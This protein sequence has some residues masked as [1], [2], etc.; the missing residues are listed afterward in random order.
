LDRFRLSGVQPDPPHDSKSPRPL[1]L[2]FHT[3]PFAFDKASSFALHGLQYHKTA[4]FLLHI[5]HMTLLVSNSGTLCT[6]TQTR[7][8]HSHS[9]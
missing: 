5:W 2:R 9:T 4:S 1:K 7:L 8:P 6:L 3:P